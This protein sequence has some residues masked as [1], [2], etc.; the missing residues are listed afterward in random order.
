MLFVTV[1][2]REVVGGVFAVYGIVVPPIGWGKALIVWAYAFVWIFM[3][4]GVKIV[5]YRIL[6]KHTEV[7]VTKR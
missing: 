2:G 5:T 3:L 4:S 6:A 7:P 1:E